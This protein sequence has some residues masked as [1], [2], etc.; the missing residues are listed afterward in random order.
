MELETTQ[1][2]Q[3][4][5]QATQTTTPVEPITTETNV[6]QDATR[7]SQTDSNTTDIERLIQ[8]A[9]D[10]A[11]N[12]LGNDNKRLREELAALKKQNLS[13][14]DLKALEI[15]ER[16]ADIADRESRLREKENRLFAIKAIKDA[17]LD[18]G[19]T[20]ALELADFIMSDSEDVMT[21][22]VKTF[23]SLV[24]KFVAAEVSRT[25]KEHGRNPDKGGSTA[26]AESS[27]AAKLGKR[28][29]DRNAAATNVLN[30]Y[31]GGKK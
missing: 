30:H 10:R 27:V 2:S 4:N 25:F 28:A 9:V 18:D 31:L 23:G 15:K 29:A 5:A 26:T 19:S 6:S 1:M 12:K 8:K 13:E 20:N 7:D 24:K 3:D 22:R 11:T 21:A 16:E 14:A 17:G